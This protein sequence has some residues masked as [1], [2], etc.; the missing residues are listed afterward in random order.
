MGVALYRKGGSH[1]VRGVKC[2]MKVFKVREMKNCID[3]GWHT[4]PEDIENPTFKEADTN[5]TG[6]LSVEEIRA[7]AKTAGIRNWHNKKIETLKKEL[8]YV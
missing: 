5:D 4:S 8:G 2:E 3:T 1:T 7:A 6:K